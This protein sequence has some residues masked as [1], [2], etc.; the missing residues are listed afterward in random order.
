MIEAHVETKPV[1]SGAAQHSGA[2][3][4]LSKRRRGDLSAGGGFGMLSVMKARVSAIGWAFRQAF[5]GGACVLLLVLG[6]SGAACAAPTI[7]V[8]GDSLSAGF[9][10]DAGQGWAAL[11]AKRLQDQH[12]PYEVVNA[13]VS[14]ETTAGGLARLPAE[15]QRVHPQLVLLEL[16]GNDGLRGGA[17]AAM[18]DHLAQMIRLTRDSGAQPVLFE[19]RIP[20]NYGPA[21]TGAFT[22]TFDDLAAD[23]RVPLVPFFLQG[24]VGEHDRWFQADGIH[25]IAAAQPIMLDA[26]WP[27]LQ[28]LLAAQRARPGAAAAP[29]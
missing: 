1:G 6:C 20:S 21:Y 18:R 5:R 28:P 24:L 8:F 29:S 13:S 19:M 26:V 9:G 25:P 10:L 23:S 22:K 2:I 16:G 17:V 27:V 4:K 12:S 7:L 15:L 3:R 14:G 11:L